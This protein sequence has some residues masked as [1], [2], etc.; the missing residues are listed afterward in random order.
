[1]S[2]RAL[3]ASA[4]APNERPAWPV[5]GPLE[6]TS[7]L[8]ALRSGRWS[9]SSG[10]R[11][12]LDFEQKY[13]A[14][15]GAR[16]CLATMNGTSAL[17][18]ALNSV[19]V[20]PGDAVLLPPYTFVATL[21]VLLMQHALP[22]F[23]DSDIET[24]QMDAA[25]LDKA[26]T[27]ECIAVM[28][29][30]L[31]GSAVDLDAVMNFARRRSLKLVED[32]CQA[33][34]GEWKGRKV[35]SWG[36]CGCFSFQASKNLNCGEG[37]ALITNDEE[38]ANRAYAFHTNGRPREVGSGLAYSRNG[39]NL[40]M[41]EFQAVI[42]LAQMTRLEEQSRI[43]EE[44]ARYLA[45]MLSKIPGVQPA[46]LNNGCTRS[47]WHLFMFRYLEE[48]GAPRAQFLKALGG[49]G[50]SASSGY[51]PLN[52]E[53][54]LLKMMEGRHYTRIYGQKRM[55][56]WLEQNE[57]PVNERL[58]REAVWLTQTVLLGSRSEM[59]RIAEAVS[60]ARKG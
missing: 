26:Y 16:Y 38:L 13:A 41:T 14:L 42:L 53:P 6:E 32:A 56:Q 46:R 55:K 43:R 23:V 5:F 3:M 27:Q 9:R 4:M 35:G 54:F 30:H 39:A 1:M 60:Q 33:H 57:C 51:T 8:E 58:C 50:V 25:K 15:T 37:G 45:G 59:E 31:G 44:N 18:A 29:V 40:R 12:V 21:N 36:D 47:A 24:F 2:R 11:K 17:I 19:D 20:G 34:M 10:G 7:V 22:I 52:R 49:K 28:P 48:A